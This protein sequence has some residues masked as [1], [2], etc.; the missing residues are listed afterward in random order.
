[1]ILAL[2]SLLSAGHVLSG[3]VPDPAPANP[4][5]G[6]NGIVLLISYAKWG[7]LIACGISVV[8]SGGLLAVGSL[9]NR[10]D[11][12]DKG[13]RA[14]IWSLGGAVVVA[15]AVHLVNGVFAAAH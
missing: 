3:V 12:A 4:A 1:M 10:P 8:A 6:S 7:A 9:S 2:S 5:V 11:H 14:L 13:K 15:I